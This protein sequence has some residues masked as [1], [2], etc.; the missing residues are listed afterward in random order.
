MKTLTKTLL[1]AALSAG[2]GLSNAQ[3]PHHPPQDQNAGGGMM[4]GMMGGMQ[5][6][7]DPAKMNAHMQKMQEHMLMMHDLSNKILA[8][9]DPKKQPALK[10]QQLEMM[11]VHHMAMMAKHQ[12]PAGQGQDHS[13]H[14][15]LNNVVQ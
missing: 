7:A 10:D 5:H 1:I 4:G 15:K 9:T 3:Q 6:D 12:A 13:Q 11:K 8:E 14:N 2:A